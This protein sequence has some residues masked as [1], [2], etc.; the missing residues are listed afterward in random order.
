MQSRRTLAGVLRHVLKA[1][2]AAATAVSTSCSPARATS[3]ATT[4]LSL[5]LN[6]SSFLL[7]LDS[8]Y[9]M[10]VG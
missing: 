6:T 9:Y 7:F 5:G 2:A 3:L 1:S 10:R 8:T 4:E